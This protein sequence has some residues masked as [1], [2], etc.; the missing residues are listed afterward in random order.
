MLSC[1]DT[2]A[3]KAPAKQD[4]QA[5]QQR[6]ERALRANLARRK[7]GPAAKKPGQHD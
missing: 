4:K 5:K 6:L 1:M 7:Q 3:P 2:K